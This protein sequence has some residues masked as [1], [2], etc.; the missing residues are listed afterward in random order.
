MIA[1]LIFFPHFLFRDWTELSQWSLPMWTSSLSP[2][3]WRTRRTSR[4]PSTAPS[5]SSSDEV[6]AQTGP[7]MT[8]MIPQCHMTPTGLLRRCHGS[9]QSPHHRLQPRS[10]TQGS[11]STHHSSRSSQ[12]H[13]RSS[14][15]SRTSR[16]TSVLQKESRHQ[17]P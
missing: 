16:L 4:H 15:L 14:Q 5:Q 17:Q 11:R 12:H 7:P 6:S 13:V 3:G 8:P 9:R 1:L 2:S 10:T